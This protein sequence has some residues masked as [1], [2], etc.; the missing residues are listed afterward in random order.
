MVISLVL[1]EVS[2]NI[3]TLYNKA[4]FG[5]LIVQN[6]PNKK[7]DSSIEQKKR[8]LEMYLKNEYTYINDDE[9]LNKY[10][11]HFKR[12]NKTYP[13]E[14]QI[15][16]IIKGKSLPEV[17]VLV[18]SMFHAE[19]KNRL[20]TSGH[21]LNQIRGNLKFELTTGNEHYL[22]IDGKDQ[23]LKK[24]DILLKDEQ[25]I[26]ANIL[27]GPA[28]HT[29]ITLDTKNAI[30]FAWCP[31]EFESNIVKNHLEDILTNL[32]GV[33]TNVLSEMAIYKVNL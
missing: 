30:Y 1:I 32:Q 10:K 33:Y 31:G 13:I 25:D 24:G 7:K 5:S 19:L 6:I 26:L 18:D 9:I 28:Q 15:Q 16:S 23:Q 8:S 27:Y 3:H 11:E 12:W 21:D 14:F 2:K 22:K 29:T 4:I 20:L 17:S